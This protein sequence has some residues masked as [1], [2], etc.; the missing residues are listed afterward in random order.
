MVS[1][2]RHR[3]AFIAAA[4]ALILA[5]PAAGVDCTRDAMVVFDGSGSMSE[6]G[7]NEMDVPRIF[8]ARRAVRRAMPAI[9]QV[10]RLGLVVYGPGSGPACERIDLRFAP[11]AD[12]ADRV[13][14][15]IDALRPAG[16]TPLTAAVQRAA[17]VL[18]AGG[19]IVL[20][21]DGKETCAGAP[22]LLAAELAADLPGLTVHVIGFKVR[23]D[24][25]NWESHG[26]DR[27]PTPVASCLAERTGGL[28]RS[29][30]TVDDLV[31]ALRETLGCPLYSHATPAGPIGP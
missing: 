8:E 26:R 13:I 22:C 6:V 19:D 18:A 2:R 17:A 28:Y 3:T 9:G 29:A 20:V 16:E 7:F 23:N 15:E 12:A 24:H 27:P 10:R 14:A 1:G 11:L 31:A 21:T 30:E 4:V 5:G 25:F